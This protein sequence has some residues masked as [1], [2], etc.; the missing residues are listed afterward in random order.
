MPHAPHA[1]SGRIKSR[2]WYDS[3]R[4]S[5][6]TLDHNHNSKKKYM[7]SRMSKPIMNVMTKTYTKA[8]PEQKV[9]DGSAKA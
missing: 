1:G 9:V 8:S 2:T 7:K 5:I 6:S 3:Y 4:V